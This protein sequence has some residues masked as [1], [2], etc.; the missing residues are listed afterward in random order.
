MSTDFSSLSMMQLSDSFFPAGLY[1]M[2]NGLETLYHQ[3]MVINADGVK[4]LIQTYYLQQ[5][6]PA[7]CVALANA[8]DFAIH[9][10]LGGVMLVDDIICKIK[11]VKEQRE[12]SMRSGRQLIKCVLALGNNPLITQYHNEIIKSHTP[13]TYP[14]SFSV[15]AQAFGISKQNACLMLFYGFGVS[16]VGAALRLGIIQHIESQQILDSLKPIISEQVNKYISKPYDQ[17]WQFSP[18]AD[19]FQMHHEKMEAKMFIT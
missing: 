5:V 4:E 1:T 2:S 19:I 17:I 16:I 7:D 13:G 9:G 6:G 12:A 8:Y 14:V 3:K 10:D 11:L 15:A 18:Q